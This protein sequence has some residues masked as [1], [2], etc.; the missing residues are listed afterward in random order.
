MLS[1]IAPLWCK[2]AVGLSCRAI[3]TTCLSLKNQAGKYRATSDRSRMLTYE[4][5][6]RPH[7]I[8]VR[9]AW[10]TW[11]SQNLEEFRQTQPYQVAQDEII[12][13]FIHGF[14]HQNLTVDGRELIIKRRGNCVY[15]AGFLQH[16]QR[17]DIRRIYW[18]FGFTEEFLSLLLKQPVKLELQFVEKETD[19]AY[20]Y[21]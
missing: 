18:M 9:K 1:R 12:R 3:S 8:G 4:M 15:I 14:L 21:I 20:N 19:L 13:R 5:A 11:H 2:M 17:L 10:L 16:S 7:H 6:Q